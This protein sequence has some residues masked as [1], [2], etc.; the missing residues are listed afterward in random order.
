M[1]WQSLRRNWHVAIFGFLATIGLVVATTKL[2]P[3][4]YVATSQMVLLPPLSQPNAGYNGVVNPYL[5]L[6]GLQSMAQ[7][8]S[9]AMMDDQTTK[10][11]KKA[12][13]GQYSVQYDPLSAGPILIV[14]ATDSSPE[15]ASA[16]LA[17]LDKE[18]PLTV[19]GLQ[20]Q[21]HISSRSFVTAEVVAR[22]STP[23][24][25]GKTQLRATG[26]AFIV[27]LVL[28]LL[29]VS[30]IDAWRIRRR[31]QGSPTGD[32][33]DHVGT[34]AA[35]AGHNPMNQRRRPWEQTSV[36]RALRESDGMTEKPRTLPESRLS[37]GFRR[38]SAQERVAR[39]G[40]RPPSR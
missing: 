26:L 27:G 17:V 23:A 34:A 37:G 39:D 3:A 32:S 16:A 13:V 4:K 8:V 31:T 25:S 28:T 21:A 1:G 35:F 38:W 6:A 40:T 9:S 14:Q 30:L 24:K 10:A 2:I 18:V 29:A 22:P 5:G 20:G 15:K 19:A 33:Y 36:V 7:V 12:G 11:L